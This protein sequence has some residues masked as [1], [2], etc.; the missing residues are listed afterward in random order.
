MA[1]TITVGDAAGISQ[2][3]I[4]TKYPITEG[5][6]AGTNKQEGRI[7]TLIP[8]RASLIPERFKVGI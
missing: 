4:K 8:T 1:S 6:T 7:S 3:E 5:L 2:K